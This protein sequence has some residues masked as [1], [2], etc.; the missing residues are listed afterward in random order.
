MKNQNA[1]SEQGQTALKINDLKVSELKKLRQ[2]RGLSTAGL[3]PDLVKRLKTVIDS[4]RKGGDGDLSK[5]KEAT[6]PNKKQKVVNDGESE[7]ENAAEA[8]VAVEAAK[9]GGAQEGAAK[10]GGGAQAA[11]AAKAQAGDKQGGG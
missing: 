9:R 4:N 7:G 8:S 3:N 6:H 10:T 1:K 11:G 5:K 2:E